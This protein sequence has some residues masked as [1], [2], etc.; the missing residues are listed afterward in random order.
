MASEIRVD[1]INSLSGV[2]TVTLSPTGVDIAGIT[3][4][5]TL[6][7]TTGI[8]TTLTATTGIV[9]TLTANTTKITT[10]IVTTLTATTGIVTTLTTNTLTA[11][12]TAKVGSGVT[13]SPDGDVFVTGVTT[14]ST[15]KVGGGVT[16]TSDGIEASGIGITCANINGEQISGR[17]NKVINGAVNIAQ[18]GPGNHSPSGSTQAYY[19]DQ[20][21][22]IATS[23]ASF[24]ATIT[25]DSSVTK[26]VG[27]DHAYK[28]T[29]D[30]TDTPTG[31]GNAMFRMKIEGQNC[32]D[33]A[34]GTS[35][36]KQVTVSFYA[37]SG[38]ANDGDQYTFQLRHFATDGTQRSINAPFTISS[39]FQRFVFTFTGDTANDI[40]NSNAL[41]MELD[42]QLAAG[43]DDISSQQTTWT[44]TNLFTC[45]TGQSNFL[46]STSN[47]FYITGV[48]LEVG[49]QATAFEH[50]SFIEDLRDCQRYYFQGDGQE[51]GA[52]LNN[53]YGCMYGSG[54]SM[55][56]VSFPTT[57]RAKPTVTTPSSHSGGGT[58]NTVYENF[59]E[60]VYYI[61]GD[62][63]VSIAPSEVKVSAEL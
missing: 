8:V 22:H 55:I 23:G 35:S 50:R 63:S 29:P 37:R 43:P 2:G 44:T 32:Q 33:L 56:K 19:I 28:V 15:V 60:I 14:S 13:L 25:Q 20:F 31:G 58:Y 48:Q 38:V 10:G 3:T 12:T 17:R 62:D 18:R 34:Y 54:N 5:A 30:A 27:F 11:N 53:Y 16:I 9:T 40:I 61:T 47:A 41:G 7:T 59:T 21:E 49:S 57:M 4:A 46:D 39:S 52:S 51:P 42:W 45:V 26:P 36:A 6:K 24:D 1:K